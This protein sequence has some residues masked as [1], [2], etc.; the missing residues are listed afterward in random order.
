MHQY[1]DELV[2]GIRGVVAAAKILGTNTADN[3]I[4]LRIEQENVEAVR[5][6]DKRVDQQVLVLEYL[7]V[8][9]TAPN[10]K[11]FDGLQRERI[12]LE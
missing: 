10:S 1:V 4:G 12:N 7:S 2:I 8:M 11:L 9:Q 3:F 5:V 6:A